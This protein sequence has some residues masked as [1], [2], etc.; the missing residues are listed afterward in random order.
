MVDRAPSS[1]NSSTRFGFL[2]KSSRQYSLRSCGVATTSGALTTPC[3]STV[4]ALVSPLPTGS[5]YNSATRPFRRMSNA[6]CG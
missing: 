3:S 2:R 5:E 6:F 1:A 4:R